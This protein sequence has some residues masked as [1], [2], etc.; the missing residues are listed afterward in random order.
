MLLSMSTV[1]TVKVP[2]PL[3]KTNK[4]QYIF[5]KECRPLLAACE[6]LFS[7]MEFNKVK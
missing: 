5:S 3:K 7:H 1:I 2:C 6:K 4:D